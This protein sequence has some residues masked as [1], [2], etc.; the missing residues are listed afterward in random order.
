[1][2]TEEPLIESSIAKR[3][4]RTL[5]A[6]QPATIRP[7][8]VSNRIRPGTPGP[9]VSPWL[10]NR[11]LKLEPT[12]GRGRSRSLALESGCCFALAL[13]L[14]LSGGRACGGRYA[15]LV[16]FPAEL[17]PPP[18]YTAPGPQG[19]GER[20]AVARAVTLHAAAPGPQGRGERSDAARGRKAFGQDCHPA[21]PVT[22]SIPKV[23]FQDRRSNGGH[24]APISTISK[25]PYAIHQ[26]YKE[27][28]TTPCGVVP[29][30]IRLMKHSSD[31]PKRRPENA[32]RRGI[33]LP[34]VHAAHLNWRV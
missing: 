28:Q 27:K 2:E 34:A 29:Q 17:R 9:A 11:L 14:T 26:E 33:Q 12:G 13:V 25:T 32:P 16:L 23:L 20:S 31:R 6:D 7:S 15:P 19:R 1:M 30:Y 18:P 21:L 5:T 3:E 8:S 4:Y 22:A 10:V 24:Q